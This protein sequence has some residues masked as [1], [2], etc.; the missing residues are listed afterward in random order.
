MSTFLLWGWVSHSR[1]NGSPVSGRPLERGYC[2]RSVRSSTSWR[3]RVRRAP[4]P[5]AQAGAEWAWRLMLEP[6]R[7]GRRYLIQGPPALLQLK[8]RARVVEAAMAAS[9]Q[10]EVERGRFVSADTHADVAV[11]VVTYNSASDIP[12]LIDDLRD[13]G[14]RPSDS[15][16]RCGQ[17]I[18][19]RH[20]RIVRAHDGHHV[21]RVRRKP[22]LRAAG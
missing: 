16:D 11:V 6:R 10:D 17:P 22:R 15:A 9:P 1:R 19:G 8:R 4:E 13:R 12:L 7:L 21:G 20:G 18:L 2:W 5:V 3:S 14:P